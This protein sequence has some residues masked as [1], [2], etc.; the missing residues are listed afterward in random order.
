ML[1]SCSNVDLPAKAISVEGS[2]DIGRENLHDDL[3]VEL[4]LRRDKDTR[5]ARSAQ[6]AID[7]ITGA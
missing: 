1:K 4:E 6:L 2:S 3:P 7:A 5:H